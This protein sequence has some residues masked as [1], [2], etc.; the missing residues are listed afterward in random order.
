MSEQIRASEVSR[1]D[2]GI[3]R[4]VSTGVKSTAESVEATFVD[5]RALTAGSREPILFDARKWPAADPKSWVR[6]ISLIEDICS[7]AAV[8]IDPAITGELGRFP[9]L[10]N[11]LIIPFQ[12]FTDEAEAMAFLR[13]HL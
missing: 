5:V 11:T 4:I 9:Q 10:L 3:I 8:V 12:I 2:D 7:A 13:K 6:F 1:D